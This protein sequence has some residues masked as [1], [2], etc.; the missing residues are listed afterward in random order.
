MDFLFSIKYGGFV[1]SSS[2]K[3]T[4]PLSRTLGDM[5]V[6][7]TVFTVFP[8]LYRKGRDVRF[9]K[10]SGKCGREVRGAGMLLSKYKMYIN[11]PGHRKR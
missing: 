5:A 11:C 2:E 3:S 4:L 10:S 1:I 8:L 9:G 6:R 7:E